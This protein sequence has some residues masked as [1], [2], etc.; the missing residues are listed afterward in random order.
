M[1]HTSFKK[2]LILSKIT[3][4]PNLQNSLLKTD[5]QLDSKKTSCKLYT[6][7]IGGLILTFQRNYMFIGGKK[8]YSDKRQTYW[9][10]AP[11]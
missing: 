1:R 11:L 10:L 9:H 2:M 8:G 7:L 4:I 6:W 3:L 5:I